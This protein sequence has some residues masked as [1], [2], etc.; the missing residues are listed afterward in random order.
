MGKDRKEDVK[1]FLRTLLPRVDFPS[2]VYQILIDTSVPGRDL[3]FGVEPTVFVHRD[4]VLSGMD[5][6]K[7]VKVLFKSHVRFLQDLRLP[8]AVKEHKILEFLSDTQMD[9]TTEKMWTSIAGI[10]GDE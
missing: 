6:R 8:A 3:R 10:K 1:L 9:M 4:M 5:V 7:R 2:D